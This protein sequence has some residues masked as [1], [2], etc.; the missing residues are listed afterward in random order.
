MCIKMD[1]QQ[2]NLLNRE[3]LQVFLSGR[4][5]DGCITTSNTNST[6]YITNCKFEEYIDFKAKLL[7]DKFKKKSIT[8]KN[9]FC[10]TPIYNMR[11]SKKY[12]SYAYSRSS[13]SSR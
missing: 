13:K 2:L 12:K 7:G 1:N 4:L 8:E 11:Y 6:Y 5:G 10:K 9:G 3:Q